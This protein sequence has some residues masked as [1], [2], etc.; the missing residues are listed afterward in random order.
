MIPSAL[1][2]GETF[3]PIRAL[4]L[5]PDFDRVAALSKD[6]AARIRKVPGLLDV[7]TSVSLNSP[8]LEVRIDRQRASDL[9]VRAA[10]VGN[11]VR[12]MIAGE[13]QISTYKEGDEQYDVT[14]QLLPEQQKNPEVLVAPH[15]PLREGRPGAARQRGHHPARRGPR[16][17]RPLQPAVPG[18][19]ST[20]TTPPTFPW[21]P[22]PAPWARRC[23][24]PGY[25]R[26]TP[27]ASPAP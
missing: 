18:R 15:D 6:A 24:R 1:G 11:A 5:G 22:P 9:G 27:S 20:A 4:I 10:D 2:G 12:L 19:R 14:L 7:D 21:T 16:A 26:A 8:E 17:H 13:D 3:F 25:P 23:A